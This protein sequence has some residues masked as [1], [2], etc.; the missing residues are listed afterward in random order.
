M[1]ADV[2]DRIPFNLRNEGYSKVFV[3]HSYRDKR[4]ADLRGAVRR[5]FEPELTPYYAD[6]ELGTRY[7]LTKLAQRIAVSRLAL[8]DLSQANPNVMVELGLALG[9]N[10]QILLCCHTKYDVP[11]FIQG[12]GVIRYHNYIQLSAILENQKYQAIDTAIASPKT[13]W[14]QLCQQRCGGR[15][16]LPSRSKYGLIVDDAPNVGYQEDFMSSLRQVFFNLDDRISPLTLK[17]ATQS[18][19]RLLCGLVHSIRK[20]RF[21]ALRFVQGMSPLVLF[22]FG[23]SF[24]LR[25][26]LIVLVEHDPQIIPSNLAGYPRF[27][28]QNFIQIQEFLSEQLPVFLKQ[29]DASAS[30]ADW[31]SKFGLKAGEALGNIQ[32]ILPQREMRFEDKL[33]AALI[34]SLY[35]VKSRAGS[36]MLL[37]GDK[38]KIEAM[39]APRIEM[40]EVGNWREFDISE[41]ICGRVVRERE[42]YSTGDVHNDSIYK[43]STFDKNL[44]SLAA[45]PITYA[46]KV[47]GVL[48]ADS[49]EPDFFNE[50]DLE[51]LG[52]VAR[53]LAPIVARERVAPGSDDYGDSTHVRSQLLRDPI[54]LNC[55][56]SSVVLSFRSIDDEKGLRYR[57][58]SKC[59]ACGHEE[60]I[61]TYMLR[62]Y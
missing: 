13:G 45:V 4:R 31:T 50:T 15:K 14:C 34:L 62:A 47:L 23:L 46:G 54:C 6:T 35:A 27:E 17:D 11:E 56:E 26:P 24:G 16:E 7:L 51:V 19:M 18:E 52:I 42:P 48:N 29:V 38:L 1:F 22:M 30:L 36:L 60:G 41:G 49:R 57:M 9:L 20:S 10:K 44:M 37:S 58:I 8:F 12:V 21:T 28:Y 53:M 25:V 3:A 2:F 5:A 43:E 32:T 39:V 55:N 59:T 40:D 61:R 33:E